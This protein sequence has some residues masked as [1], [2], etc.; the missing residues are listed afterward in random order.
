MKSNHT[1]MKN[2]VIMTV[3]NLLMRSIAVSFNAY[4]TNRIGSAGIG[5]FQLI[6][7]VY[8]LAVTLS[9]AGIKLASTRITVET[10]A[11]RLY[12]L[13]KSVRLFDLYAFICGSF[14]CVVVIAFSDLIGTEWISDIRSASPLRMLALSLPFVAMSASLSGFFTA[15][16]I[17]VRYTLIQLIEQIIKIAVAVFALSRIDV[18]DV[19]SACLA[20]ALATTASETVSFTL[21]LILKTISVRETTE[22]KAVGLPRLLRIA[23]PDATG[24]SVRSILLT[25]E[26]LLIPKGFEKA[27]TGVEDALSAYGNIHAMALPIIL[28]PSAV[29]TSYSALVIPELAKM[30]ELGQKEKISRC[31]EKNLKRTL[32]FSL[33]CSA[34]MSFFAPLISDLIYKTDEAV[35]YIR[36]LAP[37]MPVMYLDTVTDGMLKGLDQQVYSMRYNIIDSALCV[38]MVIFLLPVY[39]VKGY[40]FILYASELIN[41]YLSFGRL[42]K[43]CEIRIFKAFSEPQEDISTFVRSRKC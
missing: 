41:F 9:C 14:I 17:V 28:Y 7:T 31:V 34:V 11:N 39:S 20:I 3:S 35:Q 24:T 12:D 4:L 22:K 29:L 23:I 30:N 21:S 33:V 1:M 32:V 38:L 8:S 13:K 6:I 37:L 25:I 42:M 18:T 19:K 2:T 15:K 36:I 40:I 16:G 43:V 5:L 26:H 27:G 10:E